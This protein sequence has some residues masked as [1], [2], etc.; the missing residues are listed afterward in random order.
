MLQESD[1]SKSANLLGVCHTVGLPSQEAVEN[2][3][4]IL[5]CMPTAVAQAIKVK[6]DI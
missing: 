2:H 1:T 3:T 6:A 5:N 4:A